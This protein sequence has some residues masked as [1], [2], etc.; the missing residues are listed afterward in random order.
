MKL[1]SLF[2]IAF[3]AGGIFLSIE[4]KSF[5]QLSPR[6]IITAALL[7]LLVRNHRAGP[8]LD[9][10]R[11][12]VRV[13]G[14]WLFTGLAAS[15]LERL[16]APQNLAGTLI[17]SGKLDS[18]AALPLG[19]A[20]FLRGDPLLLPWGTRYEINLEQAESSAGVIPVSGG[21]RLTYYGGETAGAAPSAARAG[22]RVEAFARAHTV[23]NFGDPGNF[24]TRAFL[25]A[26]NIQLQGSLRN[27]QLL[28]IVD[29]PRLTISERFAR[30]RGRFLS[31]LNQLF[32]PHPDEGG[33]ARAMLLG[34][35]SFVDRDRV[36]DYQETG[37]YHVMVLAGLHVGALAAFFIWA[38]RRL[39]LGLLPRILLTILALTAYASIVEDRP[40]ILRAV[41]M[42]AIY[43]SAKLIYRRM[44]L[45]NVAALSAL[46][47][48]AVRPSELID[49]SFLLSFSAVA[50]IGAIAIPSIARSSEPYRLAL[51]HLADVTRDISHSPRV[52]QF[53]IEMRAATEWV[54]ARLPRIAA[55]YGSGLLVRPFR[56]ALFFWEIIFLS[57]ILQLGMLPPLAYYFHRVTLVGP[58]AKHSFIIADRIGGSAGVPDARGF[59]R[60]SSYSG[61][62]CVFVDSNPL[63]TKCFG[64]L[65]RRVAWREL[66]HSRAIPGSYGGVRRAGGG[67]IGEPAIALE[68]LVAVERPD[69]TFGC[70]CNDSHI[71]VSSAPC[72]AT[73][74]ELLCSMWARATAFFFLFRKGAPCWSTE[75]A[76]L[77]HFIPEACAPESTSEK[78]SFRR[79][80]GRAGSNA[81]TSWYSLMGMKITWADFQLF[82]KIF[83]WANFGLGET[84]IAQA[85]SRSLLRRTRMA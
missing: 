53:R 52:I 50:T 44:D 26:Q 10:G 71:P 42:A 35:R 14:A 16:S 31:S 54:S 25:A 7:F 45:I 9:F 4:L 8:R 29:H 2:P 47:I 80:C 75:A 58:I 59:A 83:A 20:A 70:G 19:G 41:L 84:S 72:A 81:S 37:V 77:E 76:N 36:V 18:G 27:A 12:S 79:T 5:A 56:A 65:V 85:M 33:L 39:R 64:S 6:I 17:E 74:R 46:V 48:L 13:G 38:G 73:A 60:V 15:N 63:D 51:D 3:F 69:R 78:M 11:G 34:D 67:V 82:L 49:A 57:A 55:P 40:P 32:A 61:L 66:P 68:N 43:L 23:N 62:A 21:L 28:T 22:D 30:L 24:D 1:P